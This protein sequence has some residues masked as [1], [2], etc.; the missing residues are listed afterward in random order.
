[1]EGSDMDRLPEK[2]LLSLIQLSMVHF[3]RKEVREDE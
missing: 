1:M 2:K 3:C